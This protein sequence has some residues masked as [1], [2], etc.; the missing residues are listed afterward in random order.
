MT[1]LEQRHAVAMRVNGRDEQVHVTAR[2]TLAD[3]LRHDLGL[4]GTHLGCEQGVCGACTVLLD[5]EAVRGCLTLA[6]QAWTCS[7]VS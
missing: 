6:V 5:G 4:T 7:S 3:A 2:T 1:D